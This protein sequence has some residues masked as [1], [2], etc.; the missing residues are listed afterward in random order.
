MKKFCL[1]CG[2]LL[3]VELDR[4]PEDNGLLQEFQD[5]DGDRTDSLVGRLVDGRFRVL[6]RLGSGGMGA[7][8]HAFQVSTARE[9][10][11][12]V[13]RTDASDLFA[14]R[15]EKEARTT[16]AL[17][18]V[19]T[20]TVYDF[21]RDGPGGLPYLAME[22]LQGQTLTELLRDFGPIPWARAVDILAQAAESLAEAHDKGIVHRDIKPDNLFLCPMGDTTDFVKVLDFGIAK[23]QT[24]GVTTNL[25][26]AGSTIGT[27]R[28]MAPEQARGEPVDGRADL[29]SL[30]VIFYEL[31]AG[32]PPFLD[33]HPLTLMMKHCQEPVP[34]LAEVAPEVEVPVAV[35]QILAALLEKVPARRPASA[36]LL[37]ELLAACRQ[38]PGEPL[39]G[40]PP[41]PAARDLA[42]VICAYPSPPQPDES[43]RHLAVAIYQEGEPTVCAAAPL[44][45]SRRRRLPLILLIFLGILALAGGLFAFTRLRG[46]ERPSVGATELATVP[47][48]DAAPAPD[49]RPRPLAA[50]PTNE[51][52][53]AAAPGDPRPPRPAAAPDRTLVITS[54]PA[55]ATVRDPTGKIHGQT[56][57]ELPSPDAATRLRLERP[58]YQPLTLP[59]AAGTYGRLTGELKRPVPK[60]RPK[61]EEAA[62]DELMDY[63]SE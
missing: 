13:I 58:G 1:R 29:Y 36:A 52:D 41:V 43:L 25:T 32:R 16:S 21:G 5:R 49:A 39:L 62:V 28:Y 57:L 14:E 6:T 54:I 3:P 53:P 22:L 12:K 11:L 20:V 10:A 35:A 48:D 24:S 26:G 34:P 33:E 61:V 44:P 19:H 56:P 59:V 60:P 40:L 7:V 27:A 51:T 31:L 4:C 42:T 30:G 18:N 63:D 23:L 15:F 9:V 47:V 46:P 8:Y 2:A 37:R 55:G 17:R 38:A 45:P 50:A